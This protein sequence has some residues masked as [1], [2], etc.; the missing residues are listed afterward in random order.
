[1]L[2][3]RSNHITKSFNEPQGMYNFSVAKD[4]GWGAFISRTLIRQFY[5]RVLHRD[6]QMPLPTG[7]EILLPPDNSFTSEVILTDANVD[8]GAEAEMARHLDPKGVFLDVGAH[9]GYYSLY[10]RPLVQEVHAFEPDS[11]TL[12]HLRKNLDRH[13]GM[14]VHAEAVSDR[15]GKA[16]FTLDQH[17]ELSRMESAAPGAEGNRTEVTVVSLDEFA[18]PSQLAVTGIKIDVEGNDYLVLQGANRLVARCQPLILTEAVANEALFRWAESHGY[19]VY[20][21]VG[22]R[23][24]GLRT[25]RRLVEPGAAWTKMLFLVPQRLLPEFARQGAGGRISGLR[26]S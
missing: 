9:I 11:R 16:S 20:A 4:I 5:K 3:V 7:L 14:H 13:P 19:S 25:F 22:D 10:M 17:A 18:E 2:I 12:L 15:P 1:M 21:T 24:S 26:S 6:Y 23:A 8:W